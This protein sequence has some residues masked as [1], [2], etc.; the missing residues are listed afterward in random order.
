MPPNPVPPPADLP[1]TCEVRDWVVF[2]PGPHK[3]TLYTGDD[4]RRM[5]AAFDRLSAGPNPSL[6]PVGKVG[7]DREQRLARS[8]GLPACGKVVGCRTVDAM[9]RVALDL[10]DVPTWFGAQINAGRYKAGSIEVDPHKPDPADP[11]VTIPGPILTGVA[12]L[13]EEQP[14]VQ[15]PHYPP[16]V[17]V[18][19]DGTTVPPAAD[20]IPVPDSVLAPPPPAPAEGFSATLCFSQGAPTVRDQ[21]NAQLQEMGLDPAQYAGM[22]DAQVKAVIAGMAGEQ[23]AAWAKKKFA[24]DP[25]MGAVPPPVPKPGEMAAA[26][27]YFTQFADEC[28]KMF[29]DLTQRVGSVEKTFSDV[30]KKDEDS[31]AMA[32][33]AFASEYVDTQIKAGKILFRDRDRLVR[34][35][36]EVFAKKTFADKSGDAAVA[37]WKAD[38]SDRPVN[39]LYVPAVEHPTRTAFADPESAPLMG[40]IT[41]AGGVLDRVAPGAAKRVRELAAK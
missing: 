24:A 8:L 36:V 34:E 10:V 41:R 35:G 1:P 17:A 20:P 4:C 19:A 31:A 11:A 14:A 28:K 26:P 39:P 29:G 7:H 5:V 30:Q 37:A 33:Q 21:L 13:G 40:A 38:L 22:D 15:G 23:F 12:F 25:A 9:G 3:G 27:A 18:F 6:A 2:G 32:A 16:P